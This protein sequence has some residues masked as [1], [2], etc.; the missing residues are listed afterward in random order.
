MYKLKVYMVD[1]NKPGSA[2]VAFMNPKEIK[3]NMYRLVFESLEETSELDQLFSSVTKSER[4]HSQKV[5]NLSVSDIVCFE[6]MDKT[7]EWYVKT[8]QGW[9]AMDI[10]VIEI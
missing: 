8:E 4:L 3:P 10:N 1:L 5:Q 2:Q 9:K 7:Q 6:E